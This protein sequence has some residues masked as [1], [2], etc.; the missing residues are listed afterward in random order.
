M[1]SFTT[2]SSMSMCHGCAMSSPSLKAQLTASPNA[3]WWFKLSTLPCVMPIEGEHLWVTRGGGV[4]LEVRQSALDEDYLKT[5]MGGAGL[6][7]W[8]WTGRCG[9]VSVREK[10]Q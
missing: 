7:R 2:A 3:L 5:E 10:G 6:E 1:R 9:D 4:S 8:M